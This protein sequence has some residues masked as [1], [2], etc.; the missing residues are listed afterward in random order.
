MSFFWLV[1]GR[2]RIK[3]LLQLLVPK[4]RISCCGGSYSLNVRK[5]M[6]NTVKKAAIGLKMW[7]FYV[8][9]SFAILQILQTFEGCCR[10]MTSYILKD[11]GVHYED[12]WQHTG[13]NSNVLIPIYSGNKEIFSYHPESIK[14]INKYNLVSRKMHYLRFG[15]QSTLCNI[16]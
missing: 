8:L 9:F 14:K 7:I 11:K 3:Y 4:E 12:K 1:G 13:H 6:Q 2:A 10:C 15:F 16:Q 5:C